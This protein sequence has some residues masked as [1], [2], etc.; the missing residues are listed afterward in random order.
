MKKQNKQNQTKRDTERD[1]VMN[2]HVALP[3]IV[4]GIHVAGGGST[5]QHSQA[6]DERRYEG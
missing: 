5:G 1:P 2:S 6:Q 3:E 4:Q